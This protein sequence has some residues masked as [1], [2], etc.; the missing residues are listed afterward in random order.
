MKKKLSLT[1]VPTQT[2][3]LKAEHLDFL[4]NFKLNHQIKVLTPKMRSPEVS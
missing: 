2:T 4:V 1:L 3:P